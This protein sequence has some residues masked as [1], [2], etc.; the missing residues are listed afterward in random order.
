MINFYQEYK[1]RPSS[2][3]R[4][5]SRKL[6]RILRQEIR[7]RKRSDLTLRA[8]VIL[9]NS[10]LRKFY[11]K[12]LQ[13]EKLY[14]RLKTTVNKESDLY[15]SYLTKC[16][17]MFS[18]KYFLNNNA[19]NIVLRALGLDFLLQ[20]VSYDDFHS[21]QKREIY[22]GGLNAFFV[23]TLIYYSVPLLLS[24]YDS[25]YLWTFLPVFAILLF[26]EYRNMKHEYYFEETKKTWPNKK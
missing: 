8:F 3:C 2:S 11:D 5:L 1:L 19:R 15:I 25:K 4:T 26:M 20:G 18:E 6:E 22:R 9:S 13:N 10:N 23:H 7:D 14:H 24:L 21:N 12:A 17:Q 16:D